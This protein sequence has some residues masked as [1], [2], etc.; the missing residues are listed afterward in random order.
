MNLLALDTSTSQAALVVVT[1]RG[2]VRIAGPDPSARHGRALIPAIQSL[3]KSAGLVPADLDG[4]AVGLGPG[5][6]TGLRVGLTAA[7]TLAY[8]LGKPLAGFDSL[9]AIA[10]NA[11][12][13][14]RDVAVIADAQR[15]DLYAADFAR[16]APGGPLRRVGSTRVVALD[17]W[18]RERPDG[19]FVLGPALGVEKLAA[20][21]PAAIARPDD[22]GRNSPDPIRL[23][24]FAREVW[25]SGRRD[26]PFF[27]EPVYLRRSAAEDQ[28]DA[29]GGSA[30]T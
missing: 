4:L 5:S 30:A 3:L 21:I 11:P 1:T 18:L 29:R 27:L 13:S 2:A 17:R 26:E 12:E 16:D 23:A 7:K 9:E 24:E 20:L 25:A 15:G 10:W 6:Y 8:A 19:A 22:P 14:A 28:W